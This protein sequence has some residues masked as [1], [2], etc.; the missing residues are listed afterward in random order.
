MPENPS[1][2]LWKDERAASVHELHYDPL[3]G[4][5][6][7]DPNGKAAQD[8][9]RRMAKWSATSPY[10]AHKALNATVAWMDDEPLVGAAQ[11]AI[12]PTVSATTDRWQGPFGK[13][14]RRIDVPFC[15]TRPPGRCR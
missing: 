4:A 11:L 10:P 2:E 14:G 5:L 15:I 12:G 9:F 7:G 13:A 3:A 1:G 6:S 8:E